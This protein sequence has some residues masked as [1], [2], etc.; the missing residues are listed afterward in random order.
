MIS[1]YTNLQ[2]ATY[3]KAREIM[4]ALVIIV[5]ISFSQQYNK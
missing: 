2:A 5:D 1:V 3:I 4:V